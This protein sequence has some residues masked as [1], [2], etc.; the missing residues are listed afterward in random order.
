[1]PI[2]PNTNKYT[3]VS[4][5]KNYL[6]SYESDGGSGINL[7][8]PV[9]M[10]G[11]VQ[12]LDPA[13]GVTYYPT[14]NDYFIYGY[15]GTVGYTVDLTLNSYKNGKILVIKCGRAGVG[16]NIVCD[17]DGTGSN[18]TIGTACDN[19]SVMLIFDSINFYWYIMAD[20]LYCP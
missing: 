11:S 15:E 20:Y 3:V 17:I 16:I 9:S 12:I 8:S 14:D 19:H 4:N 7:N 1:M 6:G 5:S 10:E 2:V 18:L 13:G